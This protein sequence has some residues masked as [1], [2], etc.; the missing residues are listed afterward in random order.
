MD[1]SDESN[2]L[3]ELSESHELI[4]SNGLSEVELIVIIDKAIEN[5]SG[6][7]SHICTA[8]GMLFLCRALG[9][10]AIRLM[11]SSRTYRNSQKILDIQFKDHFKEEG[12]LARKSVVL[13]IVKKFHNFW[14]I[15]NGV[16]SVKNKD[17][18]HKLIR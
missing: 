4:E 18:K 3:I 17:E 10:R 11:F 2:T 6:G 8:I 12:E 5:Y 15:V 13:D 16:E 1:K 14:D 9:W 7:I